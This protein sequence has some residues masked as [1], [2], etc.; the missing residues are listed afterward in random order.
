MITKEEKAVDDLFANTHY[1]EANGRYVV[2]IPIK[3]GCE[4][5]GESRGK[6]LNHFLQLE[7][8][9]GRKPELRQ[10][11]VEFMCNYMQL[12]YMQPASNAYN[13]KWSYWLPHHAVE[14]KF[15]VVF[16]ASLKTTSGESLNSIQMIGR[17]MQYDLQLQ[18]MRFRRHKIGVA[19]NISKMFNRIG[20]HPKQWDLQRI[21]WRESPND[22][23]KEYVL[24][25]VTFGLASSAH[26]TVSTL[27][28]CA[29]DYEKQFPEAAEI[30][31][32]CF[33]IDDGTF[34]SESVEE[35]KILCKEIEFVLG[36]GC[37]PIKNWLSNSRA[38]ESYMNTESQKATLLGEKDA[39]ISL[40][41]C[42]LKT[43]NELIIVMRQPLEAKDK[44]TK[45]N[46][47]SGIARLYDPNGFIAPIIIT[48]KILMQDIW[49]LS[50]VDWDDEVPET[51]KSKWLSLVKELPQLGRFRIKRWLGTAKAK[52]MQLHA[53]CG[54]SEKAYG[55]A[56]Y[57]RTIDE[58]G[59]ITGSLLSAKSRVAPLKTISIPRLELLAAVMLSEQLETIIEACGF[60]AVEATLWSDSI[61]VL[62]WIK[63]QPYELKAFVANR[64]KSIQERTKNFKWKQ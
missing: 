16:N 34:G 35:E 29:K 18:I 23:L 27:N 37:L 59:Q 21:F 56:I 44:L 20:V 38:I 50:D 64:I 36:Q 39:E 17:K 46:I 55:I 42:W 14:K 12:G 4:G 40:G 52:K 45:R 33:Y 22:P 8:R 28:Q 43:T 1:R 60:H 49:R 30:I 54:A 32:T 11:Y 53:F 7:R 24:T 41:L 5:L 31:K 2:R 6:V 58:N 61:V 57:V 48:S 9:F 62:H 13:A 47:L 63:K 10:K 26:N 51:I 19:I 25:V 15:R 3:P